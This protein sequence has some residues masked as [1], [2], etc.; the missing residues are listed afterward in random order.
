MP[1]LNET[2]RKILRLLQREG[3]LSNAE[4]ARR[5]G[6]SETPCLRRIRELE[7]DGVITGY[8]AV[9]NEAKAGLPIAAFVLISTDQRTETDRRQF[10][11]AV[12]AET[13][14]LSCAA[15]AGSHD[16]ILYVVAANMAD[17]GDLLM[18]RLLALPSVKDISS[19]IVMTWVKR[20][21]TL[22]L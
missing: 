18:K 11:D 13:T 2:N 12:Q 15:I 8:R 1:E 14:I 7:Q 20:Q 6:L 9:I 21:D 19:S 10:R 5:I 17:L 3:R 16:F 22:P 4:V